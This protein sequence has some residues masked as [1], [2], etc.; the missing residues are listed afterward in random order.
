MR[1]QNIPAPAY[2][3]DEELAKSLQRLWPHRVHESGAIHSLLCF[4]GLH[5]WAQ[6]DL[7]SHAPR[8]AVKFCLWCSAVE[9]DGNLYS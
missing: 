5:F 2:A 8:R 3:R 9:I 4:F 7:S 6:P 1:D